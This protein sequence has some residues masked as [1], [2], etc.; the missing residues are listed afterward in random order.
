VTNIKALPEFEAV[1]KENA[2]RGNLVVV[3]FWTAWAPQCKQVTDVITALAQEPIYKDVA[4]VE[5]EAEDLAELS[6]KYSVSAVPTCVLIK[7]SNEVARVNGSN[8]PLLNKKIEEHYKP[9]L[10][11]PTFPDAPAP[12]QDLNTRLKNL[13]NQDS[14]MLFMKGNADEPRCGFSKK[15]VEILNKHEAKFSTFDILSDEEVRQGLKTYSN[16]P[17]YPQLYVDGELIG[18]FDI[19]K[20]MDE[21]GELNTVLPKKQNIQERLKKLTNKSQVMVFMKGSPDKPRCGFSKTLTEILNGTGMK[22][23]TFDILEDEVVRQ[24]LKSYSNWPTYPQVYVNG[25]LIGGLDIIKELQASGELV[26]S[27]KIN[28]V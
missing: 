27:L 16:W 2:S 7:N 11:I 25:E 26:S 19:I 17:T 13:V 24:E 23:E 20:E 28:P 18:G 14:C 9:G 3:H 10:V 6:R 4:F 8:V 21:N 15:V 5:V 1:L 22:Y 12:A